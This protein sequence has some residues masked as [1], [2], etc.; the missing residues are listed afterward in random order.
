MTSLPVPSFPTTLHEN[1]AKEIEQYFQ[2]LPEIDTVLV[3]NSCARGQAVPESDLDFAILA[4][5]ATSEHQRTKI[6]SNWLAYSATNANIQTYK[7]SGAYAHIHLDIIEG[8]YVPQTIECGEPIDFFEVEIGNQLCYS[9]PMGQV[10][11]Y[12][13]ELRNKWLPYY[14]DTLRTERLT[15]LRKA[16]VYDIDHVPKFMKRGLCFQAF[17]ILYKAF[18]EYLQMLFIVNKTYPLAYNKWIKE[19]VVKWLALPSLYPLLPQLI[20]IT[21]IESDEMNDKAQMIR[22]LVNQLTY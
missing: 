12:F 6:Y 1:V 16:C 18:H 21:N 13:L 14:D 7:H 17:E 20:S 15:S 19:Q 3:V 9:A 2:G 11:D 4:K 5:P 8:K 10:G 22:S